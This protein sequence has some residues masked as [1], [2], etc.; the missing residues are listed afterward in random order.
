MSEL[1]R[2]PLN[3]NCSAVIL[4]K[5]PK[6]L[7]DP[8]RFL[9]PCEFTGITT[10]NALAD[11]GASINLMPYSVWKDLA[12]PELTPT[13]MTLELI[14]RSSLNQYADSFL[15]LEDDQLHL[16]LIQ[17]IRIL[18]GEHPDSRSNLNNQVAPWSL[19]ILQTT[20]GENSVI[21][22][23]RR[24]VSGQ[25]ALDILKACHSGPTGDNYG[26]IT[27][28]E[29]SRSGFYCPT[30]Y[31]EWPIGLC[32]P[33]FLKEPWEKI[34]VPSWS[35]TLDDAYAASAQLTKLPRV[36]YSIKIL[37][38]GRHS[39][40]ERARALKPYWA[41]KHTNFDIQTAGDHRKVQL[42]ELNELRDQAYENSLIYKEKTKRIHD[43]K[44]KNRVFNVG[45]RVLLFNSRLKIFSGKLKSRWS[46]P[47]TIVQVFPYGTVELSQNSGPN[48]KVNGH[49]IKHYFGGDIPTEDFP[50]CEDSLARS[51]PQE[52][53][54]LS[55]SLGIQCVALE[56][57]GTGFL[58]QSLREVLGSEDKQIQS[59]ADLSAKAIQ[60]YALSICGESLILELTPT[61]MILELAYRSTTSPS[62]IA[63]D[64]FV[65]I[66]KFQ[67][68]ADFIVV[69]YVV[70]PRVPLILERPCEDALAFD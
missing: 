3:E 48:F 39:S 40:T 12:L 16:K 51:I 32:H 14:D 41:L 15:A 62:G 49:R 23:I 2:T 13:C 55:F 30:I 6:K 5:L 69:D 1:A 35:D 33:V 29:K 37:C 17:L 56:A 10:C 59:L 25:E 44:I 11:L 53:H 70:D 34:P 57:L 4:N 68:P 66:G 18:K 63:K 8:G 50:D 7:G 67:F 31:K 43:A 20:S 42:N 19:Q 26:A 9:I 28:L 46:G 61:Q 54:I 24:C 64:V 45:D 60:P 65:K 58:C 21:K 27:P 22:V 36:G 38:T 52:F 47:F